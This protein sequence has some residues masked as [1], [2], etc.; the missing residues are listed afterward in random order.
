LWDELQAAPG[1]AQAYL[2]RIHQPIAN[3]MQRDIQRVFFLGSGLRYGLANEGA[4]KMKEMS[5]TNAE[6]F[7]FMEFRHGPQ[8]MV[9]ERTLVVGL[10]SRNARDA[11]MQVLREMRA[12]GGTVVAIGDSLGEN[13]DPQV[14]QIGF[15]AQSS[16]AAGLVFYMP[17]LQLLAYNQAKRAAEQARLEAEQEAQRKALEEETN[18]AILEGRLDDA[19][20]IAEAEKYTAEQTVVAPKTTVKAP[21]ATASTVTRWK[22]EVTNPESVP[23]EFCEPSAFLINKAVQNGTRVIPGVRIWPEESISVR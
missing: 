7:H 2:D 21:Q 10:V 1:L 11:E 14:L 18:K 23:R 16:E 9:D 19:R 13:T 6:P 3:L 12:F 15:P 4:L 8:S 17:V 20:K 5:L 22:Y